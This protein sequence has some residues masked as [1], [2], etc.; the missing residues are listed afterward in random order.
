MGAAKRNPALDL[1][2]RAGMHSGDW[3]RLVDLS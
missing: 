2:T 1:V 3:L